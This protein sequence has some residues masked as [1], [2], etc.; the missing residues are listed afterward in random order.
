MILIMICYSSNSLIIGYVHVRNSKCRAPVLNSA[1]M[2]THFI[3]ILTIYG[4]KI[5]QKEEV[6]FVAWTRL[7]QTTSQS[8][9]NKISWRIV[10]TYVN[11]PYCSKLVNSFENHNISFMNSLTASTTKL[12]K[13]YL[14]MVFSGG[15]WHTNWRYM[16]YKRKRSL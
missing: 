1:V 10:E 11:V 5:M 14:V 6:F 4:L 3:S 7:V 15:R 8:K 13:M 12:K 16:L 9:K 2:Y